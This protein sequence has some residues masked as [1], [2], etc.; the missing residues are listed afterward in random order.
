MIE[1]IGEEENEE[2][3]KSAGANSGKKSS[4]TKAIEPISIANITE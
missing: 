2:E 1:E 3:E 4:A